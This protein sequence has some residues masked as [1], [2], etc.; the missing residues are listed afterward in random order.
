[1]QKLFI[2]QGRQEGRLEG[3]LEGQQQGRQEGQLQ[4]TQTIV[5]TLLKARFQNLPEDIDARVS[6]LSREA[7]EATAVKILSV[8]SFEE[9]GI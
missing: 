1:M 6:Q 5:L 4:A 2:K 7:A 9:L 8:N 3:R